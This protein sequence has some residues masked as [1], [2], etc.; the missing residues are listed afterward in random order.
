MSRRTKEEL[1]KKFEIKTYGEILQ[2]S[3]KKVPSGRAITRI[4]TFVL[5]AVALFIVPVIMPDVGKGL[6]RNKVVSAIRDFELKND[7]T[8]GQFKRT[9]HSGDTTP[10]YDA[11]FMAISILSDAGFSLGDK[12]S[13]RTYVLQKHHA[14]FNNNTKE[15]Y[16]GIVLMKS[17]G[18]LNGDKA[19]QAKQNYY[20]LLLSLTERHAAFRI[21]SDYSASVDATYFAFEAIKE[22]GKMEDFKTREEFNSAIH[23]VRS[24]KHP[25]SKGFRNTGG[26]GGG[27]ATLLATWYAI[28]VLMTQ[29]VSLPSVAD[30]FEGVENFVYSCQAKDGG[31]LNSPVDSHDDLYYRKSTS[32]A[33]SQ[34]V[35]VL[36]ALAEKGLISLAVTSSTSGLYYAAVSYLRACLSLTNG[37]VSEYPSTETDLDGTFY[38]LKLINSYNSFTYGTP[39]GL[40]LLSVGLGGLFLVAAVY[41]F[42]R[43]QLPLGA[44]RPLLGIFKNSA[45]FLAAGAITL[46]WCPQCAVITYTVFAVYL[47][48]LFFN[49]FGRDAETMIQLVVAHNVCF[50]GMVFVFLTVSPVIFANLQVFYAI[51]LWGTASAFTISAVG[52]YFIGNIRRVKFFATCGL[53]AWIGNTVLFYS[54]LYGRGEIEVIYRMVVIHGHFPL[55]FF[56]LPLA[57]LVATYGLSAY[58]AYLMIDYLSPESSS[59]EPSPKNAPKKKVAAI[60]NVAEDSSDSEVD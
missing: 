34:A 28:Q 25:E 20:D 9:I 30:A 41:A 16:Q 26:V 15:I 31:F 51:T 55:V 2:F 59:P 54:F 39:R 8:P 42:V 3:L 21:N 56:V 49:S 58:G 13:S 32:A 1:R 17:L 14:Q 57:S 44:F 7:V 19:D 45:F 18:L 11:T 47:G 22:L 4:F 50:V 52:C 53:L 24:A 46:R 5:V 12:D 48:M 10:S 40:Q 23:F 60:K 38:F 37:V 29:D 33:T 27:N 35:F 6:Y 43:D 36:S